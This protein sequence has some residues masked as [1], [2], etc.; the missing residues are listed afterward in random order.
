MQ[1]CALISITQSSLQ[2]CSQ[3]SQL[4]FYLALLES[5]PS[6]GLYLCQLL[7]QQ[8]PQ[9]FWASARPTKRIHQRKGSAQQHTPPNQRL[10]VPAPPLYPSC[11]NSLNLL[12]TL[13]L[14]PL[15]PV[16]VFANPSAILWHHVVSCHPLSYKFLAANKQLPYWV[17]LPS[18]AWP[19][20]RLLNISFRV[21]NL[22]PEISLLA[23]WLSFLIWATVSIVKFKTYLCGDNVGLRDGCH[24]LRVVY[25]K[26]TEETLDPYAIIISLTWVVVICFLRVSVIQTA[27]H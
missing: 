8:L 2:A 12:S 5:Y 27:L 21:T 15:N 7:Y 18:R 23:V 16:L 17:I 25:S 6:S 19:P 24:G 1:T 11:F 20:L 4:S 9:W 22:E 3:Y 26:D 14:S 10:E 13:V